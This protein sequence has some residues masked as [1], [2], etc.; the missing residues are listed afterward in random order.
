MNSYKV[1]PPVNIFAGDFMSVIVRRRLEYSV[2]PCD[3][4]L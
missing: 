1:N 2:G 3:L 4:E